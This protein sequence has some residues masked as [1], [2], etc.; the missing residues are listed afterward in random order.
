MPDDCQLFP[1]NDRIGNARII[2]IDFETN[3]LEVSDKAC[4]GSIGERL[5]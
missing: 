2:G 5:S 1:F 3:E 4:V